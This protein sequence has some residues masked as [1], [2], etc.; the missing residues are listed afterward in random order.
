MMNKLKVIIGLMLLT[1]VVKAQVINQRYADSLSSLLSKPAADTDRINT[2][3]RLANYNSHL[4]NASAEQLKMAATYIETARRLNAKLKKP[5]YTNFV[6]FA[7]SGLYKG[8]G[9]ATAGKAL[10]NKV[11]DSLKAAHDKVL[12]GKAY[13]EMSEYYTGDFLQHTMLERIRYLQL[14]ISA[15]EGTNYLVEL[16]RCYRFLAD[17][18]QLTNDDAIAFKEV[19][20]AL[21][22]YSQANFKEIQGAVALL[23]RLYYEEGDYKQALHYE[24]TALKIAT[25]STQDNVRL[26]CQIN[27]NIGF[28]YLKLNEGEKS[29]P[30]F[31]EALKIAESEKDNGTVYLLAANIASAYLKLNQ[32]QKAQYFFEDINKKY[33]H[34]T[35]LKY[36]GGDYGITQTY[37]RIFMA[38][39]KY[40]RA[41]HYCDKL[42]QTAKNPNINLYTLSGYYEAIASYFIETGNYD[43]ALGYLKKNKALV[44]SVKDFPGMARNYTLWFSLDTARNNYRSA[45]S[46]IISASHINDSLFNA[47]KSRQIALLQVE[48]ETDKKESQ[49][50]FLNQNAVI[51]KAKLKQADLVKNV[52]AGGI[53]LLLVIAGLL[54]KQNRLRQKSNEIV[55]QKNELLQ[56]LLTEKEWLLKEIHH[57]VKNN[58]HTVICL[59][60]SQAAYL[61]EDALRAI[62]SSQNRIYAMSLIHQKLYQ[63]DDIKTINM[64]T[65]LA[66]FTQYLSDSFGSPGNI[67]IYLAVEKIK[68]SV[69]QA[70]PLGLIINE[71]VTNAFKYAFPKKAQGSIT[72]ELRETDKHVEMVIADT[73]IGMSYGTSGLIS[74]S[75]GLD[76]MRGLTIE[77]NGD[78]RFENDGGTKITVT[79]P[80]E[81]LIVSNDVQLPQHLNPL[82]I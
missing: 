65:Y 82:E 68:L 63:S 22:Y 24:L 76:L 29:I 4:R 46:N 16:A 17:L 55:T 11:I 33:A 18:H 56:S 62:E 6:L 26:I 36:E 44:T 34:P 73:G 25:N 59:L 35:D 53:V 81:T 7:Q 70:I 5:A 14:A 50:R 80:L 37:L 27:N 3:L 2:L 9:N 64:D 43:E 77:L 30:Y 51:E 1:I 66:E 60:E 74:N 20:T 40:D 41:K 47:T 61:E 12:L 52:T 58:L 23:G 57:R 31:T 21:K 67:R 75:L 69:A 48:Y 39:K 15:F 79:F 49:I 71:A 13:F 72:I 8:S 54:Y 19:R 10:L 78:I 45:V 42:I 32:P 28:T 38:L